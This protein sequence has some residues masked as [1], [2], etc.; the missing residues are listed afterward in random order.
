MLEKLFAILDAQSVPVPPV[1]P[2]KIVREPLEAASYIAV[3][4][5]P[6]VPPQNT[7]SELHHNVRESLE[8]RAAIMEYDGGL[9]RATAEHEARQ[10]MHVYVYRH[11]SKPD[12]DLFAIM[13]N[14]NLEEARES[15]ALRFGSSFLSVK[16]YSAWR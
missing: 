16:E 9:P 12:I 13:P 15:L 3:P 1:P 14:C 10:S 5:V 11:A 8:E 7:I 2:C 6:P 4:S